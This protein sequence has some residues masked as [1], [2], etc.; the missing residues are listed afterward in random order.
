MTAVDL[1]A[2]RFHYWE[3]LAATWQ[4]LPREARGNVYVAPAFR[5]VAPNARVLPERPAEGRTVL[6]A[7]VDDLRHL[8]PG[9]VPVLCEHGIGQSYAGTRES[10]PAAG[11]AGGAGRGAVAAFLHPNRQAADRDRAAYPDALVE[12]VGYPRL[13]ALQSVPAAPPVASQIRPVLAVTFHWHAPLCAETRSG[14]GYWW[15]AVR[16]LHDLGT[17]EVLGHAHPKLMPDVARVYERAGI[18]VVRRFED[19]LARAHCLA[20]DN[21]SAGME[22]AVVRGPVVV[23]DNPDYRRHVEHGLRFWD[24]ADVGPRIS[25]PADLGAAVWEALGGQPWPGAAERLARVFPAVEDP[26]ATAARLVLKW[27]IAHASCV[28]RYD[29]TA[30]GQHATLGRDHSRRPAWPALA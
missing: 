21:T 24:C 22:F 8:G 2:S 17:F 29:L 20:F 10:A 3:H 7:S 15:E 18:E 28:P 5:A 12:V 25:D 6:V 16:S 26:A 1:V 11:Y 4:A 9:R 14:F 13:P 19:V 23:L 30:S 27:R